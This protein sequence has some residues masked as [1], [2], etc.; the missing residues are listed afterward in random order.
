[1]NKAHLFSSPSLL[2]LSLFAVIIYN[3]YYNPYG[4]VP[5]FNQNYYDT[6]VVPIYPN[7][8]PEEKELTLKVQTAFL[9]DPYLGP[10]A[11]QIEV[12]SVAQE[13]TLSGLVDSDRI[14]LSAETKAKNT[15]GVKRVVNLINVQKTR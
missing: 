6:T 12:H 9:E 3:N 1:M 8:T 4:Q 15:L 7:R 13:I 11:S 5:P 14:R 2:G 10:Y